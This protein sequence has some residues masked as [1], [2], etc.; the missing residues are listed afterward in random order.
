MP[1]RL[2]YVAGVSPA[3]WLRVWGER[4]ADLPLEA[5]RVEQHEQADGLATGEV[6]LAFVRLPI[7][8]EGTRPRCP[9][10]CRCGRRSPSPCCRTS[11]PL[12]ERESLALADL[13]GEQRAPASARPGDDRRTRRRR[14]RLR[15]PAARRRTAAPPQRRGRDSAVGCPDHAHRAGVARRARRRRH[16]GVRRRRARAHGAQLARRG[17]RGAAGRNPQGA[18]RAAKRATAQAHDGEAGA[19]RKAARAGGRRT[20][21]VD[22][23][24]ALPLP[25][26]ATRGRGRR[27]RVRIGAT[28]RAGSTPRGSSTCDSTST[29][30]T[31]V[32]STRSPASSWAAVRST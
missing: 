14:H 25:L 32:D 3:K 29:R 4:R 5:V 12:A 11:M 22:E 15:G 19:L 8:T 18:P 7:D 20:G 21:G 9:K 27:P 16:P 13:D 23:R 10:S 28:G 6:D 2:R 24:R 17:R 26:G 30:S 1:L 31:T